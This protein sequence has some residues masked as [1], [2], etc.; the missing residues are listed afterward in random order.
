MSK[1]EEIVKGLQEAGIDVEIE[2]PERLTAEQRTNEEY[3]NLGF[4]AGKKYSAQQRREER[5][6]EREKRMEERKNRKP[7]IERALNKLGYVKTEKPKEE[8]TT[9]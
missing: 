1:I 2:V 6:I 7:F 9:E 4:E 3:Y 8:V 5:R